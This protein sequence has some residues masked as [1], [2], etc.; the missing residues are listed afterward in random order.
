MSTAVTGSLPNGQGASHRRV[1]SLST[2]FAA[3]PVDTG[4]A[5]AIRP[6]TLT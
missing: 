3:W 6:G 2:L 1:T 5:S 4:L